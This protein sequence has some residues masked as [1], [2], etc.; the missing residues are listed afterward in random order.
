MDKLKYLLSPDTI[1]KIGFLFFL[2][3]LSL[4]QFNN[5]LLHSIAFPMECIG[6]AI[7]IYWVVKYSKGNKYVYLVYAI[8][9]IAFLLYAFI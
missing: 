5:S 4:K 7:L 3:G 1:K 9:G 6:I 8:L 2:V